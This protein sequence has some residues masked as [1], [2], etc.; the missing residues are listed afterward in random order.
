MPNIAPYNRILT[1]H[2]EGLSNSAIAKEVGCARGTVIDILKRAEQQQLVYPQDTELTDIELHRLLHPSARRLNCLTPD[3]GPA[4]FRLGFAKNNSRTLWEEYKKQCD[5]IGCDALPRA[6]YQS[7][8]QKYARQYA[9][10][11]SDTLRM[12]M[13]KGEIIPGKSCSILYAELDHS[14]FCSAIVLSDDKPRTWIDA[15]RKILDSIGRLPARI[16]FAGRIP[17]AFVDETKNFVDYYY[18][19]NSPL[20]VEKDSSFGTAF[21][22]ACAE[23]STY[24]H[25]ATDIVRAACNAI[26]STPLY[27]ISSFNCLDAILIQRSTL[28]PLPRY[29]YGIV[30]IRHPVVQMNFH[31]E[32][33]GK[34]Y[35]V[36]YEHLHETVEAR[37]RD[38]TVTIYFDDLTICKH[39]RL[40]PGGPVYSTNPDHMPKS[41]KDIPYGSKSGTRFRFWAKHIGASTYE[42]IDLLLKRSTFEPQAYNSCQSILM[43]SQKYG[44]D[45][46]EAVCEAALQD[47]NHRLNTKW[48]T[49][50]MKQTSA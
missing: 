49:E 8:L 19:Y 30:E 4:L 35:S 41:D 33:E 36:P 27:P 14:G 48:I 40:K 20:T 12:K 15:C 6:S 21:L 1:L 24:Y 25:Y 23:Q 16:V 32:L 11:H 43:L 39:E 18:N 31:V 5:Q 10:P 29:H 13:L 44:N 17:K 9:S 3:Y 2:M 7:E 37:I 50:T 45:L 42:A 34:Y 47:V 22:L 38:R 46:L 26:N 28:L